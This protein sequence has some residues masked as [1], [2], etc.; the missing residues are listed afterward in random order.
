MTTHS[1]PTRSRPGQAALNSRVTAAAVAALVALAGGGWAV[2]AHA[3]APSQ[4]TLVLSDST[5]SYGDSVTATAQVTTAG[6]AD[7][8]VVFSV[9]GFSV[10][11]NISGGMA[12]VTLPRQTAVGE[13]AVTASFVPRLPGQ[14]PSTSATTTW[15]VSKAQTFLQARITGRGAHVPTGVVIGAIGDWGTRPTGPVT[16]TARHLRTG[17]VTR[18][19]RTLDPPGA[20]TA[21]LGVLRTGRYR[22][23]VTYA[24]DAQHLAARYT[25]K[26]TVR[27]R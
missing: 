19:E 27:Q 10:R 1:A 5:S 16:V 4:T 26:F 23:R 3:A 9:D 8:D 6:P 20:A 14:D 2:P 24:G 7:G 18:R 17:K 22:L 13:H 11:A 25:E 21:R 15:V 12:R